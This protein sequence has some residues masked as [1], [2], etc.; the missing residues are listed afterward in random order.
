MLVIGVR[1]TRFVPQTTAEIEAQINQ[2]RLE[3]SSA[4]HWNKIREQWWMNGVHR[5]QANSGFQIQSLDSLRREGELD[6]SQPLSAME[7]LTAR[8]DHLRATEAARAQE[9]KASLGQL[10]A[11]ANAMYQQGTELRRFG[12]ASW[13]TTCLT[14]R[15]NKDRGRAQSIVG[16]GQPTPRGTS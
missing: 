2:L 1:G 15:G 4:M 10:E 7:N 5:M 3:L 16:T 8:A 13:R 6:L 11:Q 14:C 12:C 9:S